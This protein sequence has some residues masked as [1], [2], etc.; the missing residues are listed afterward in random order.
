M[1]IRGFTLIELLTVMG[2]LAV[3]AGILF[4]VLSNAKRAAEKTTCA[5]NLSQMHKAMLLYALDA[6]DRMPLAI[7]AA[8]KWSIDRGRL[9]AGFDP[10]TVLA[11]A[12]APLI[13]D[14]LSTYKLPLNAWKSPAD[15]VPTILIEDGLRPTFYQEWGA[16][17]DYE[18]NGGL[19]SFA[20]SQI[21]QPSTTLSFWTCNGFY[22][23]GPDGTRGKSNTVAF[24]GHVELLTGSQRVERILVFN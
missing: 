2:I 7:S 5:N 3:L 21:D 19:R 11:A 14:S 16:S 22:L 12:T 13:M 23:A 6:D 15:R 10:S 18:D 8:S 1:K 17:Y 9:P 4:P 20:L 24:D